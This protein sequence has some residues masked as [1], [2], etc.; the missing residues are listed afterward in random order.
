MTA[1]TIRPM[2]W[3]DLEEVLAIEQQVFGPTAW[4]PES[5]WGELARA[6]RH[7]VVAGEGAVEGYAGLWMVPPDADVQTIAVAPSA[8]GRGLGAAL[9]EHIAGVAR[10]RGCRRLHLEVRAD[11]TVA[12]ALYKKAGFE[13]VRRRE[14][15]YPDFSDALV[16]G[17]DL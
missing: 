1:I 15:Y 13:V 10:G 5:Y 8:Q 14:R 16:M 6:D 7:Y 4:P 2:K 11:N 12:I 3:W 9:L 17:S